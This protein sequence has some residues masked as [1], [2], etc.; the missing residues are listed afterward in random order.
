M[1]LEG[2]SLGAGNLALHGWLLSL[3]SFWTV[4]APFYA[5]G[6]WIFGVTPL[7]LN[8]IPAVIAVLVVIVAMRLA[9]DGAKGLPRLVA[10]VAVLAL[11]A[12]PSPDLT[13]YLLQGPWHI[14]TTLCCLVAFLG[15]SR[16][17]FGWPWIVAVAALTFGLLGDLTTLAIGVV[18]VICAGLAVMVRERRWRVGLPSLSAGLAAIGAAVLVR[19]LAQLAGTFAIAS[20]NLSLVGSH[21]EANFRY[22]WRGFAG[23]FGVRTLK[24]KGITNGAP[25]FHVL[26]GI[27][28]L[29]VILAALGAVYGLV[30]GLANS[31]RRSLD[32]DG[33]YR[34]NLLCSPS[35]PMWSFSW[36]EPRTGISNS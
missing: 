23:L 33:W 11:V 17:R 6:I 19:L 27:A 13:D 29:V 8:L 4:D 36:L 26:H 31:P 7:L 5:V 35:L 18:P 2:Q 10:V 3:D 21:A 1:L 9:A 15:A 25:A 22:L 20:R 28:L 12:L 32:L 16:Q 14:G 30:R 24:L 34:D